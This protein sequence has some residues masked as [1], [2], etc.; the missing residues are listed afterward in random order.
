[1]ILNEDVNI[2]NNFSNEAKDL[3]LKL[4]EKNVNYLI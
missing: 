4:L 3:I 1:M 2:P